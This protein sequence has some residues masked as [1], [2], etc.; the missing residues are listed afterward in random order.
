MFCVAKIVSVSAAGLGEFP[1]WPTYAMS[2]RRKAEREGI[3]WQRIA[4][5]NFTIQ[6]PFLACIPNCI[7]Y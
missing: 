4:F 2:A 5:K 6:S 7:S 1:F 3:V